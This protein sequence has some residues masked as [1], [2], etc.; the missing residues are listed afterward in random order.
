MKRYAYFSINR[1]YPYGGWDD[2]L[3]LSDNLAELRCMEPNLRDEGCDAIV[4]LHIGREILYRFREVVP[5]E[6]LCKIRCFCTP[7]RH[8]GNIE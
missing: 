6:K 8:C 3:A 5:S 4:D 1:Y 2:M 7:W